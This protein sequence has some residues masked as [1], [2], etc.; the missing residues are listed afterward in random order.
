M[1]D[2][3]G[4]V[5]INP[6]EAS[7]KMAEQQSQMQG[8]LDTI[9]AA[10]KEMADAASK[11]QFIPGAGGE[12]AA[13]LIQ[14][15]QGELQAQQMTQKVAAATDWENLSVILGQ[16]IA[17]LAHQQRQL[18][19]KIM[20]DSAV[21][22]WDDP[23]TAIANAF[24]LPWD[25]QALDGIDTKLKTTTAMLNAAHGHVQQSAKSADAI[26]TKI[27]DAS[28][29]DVATA[30]E[31]LQIQTAA[32]A[33]LEAAKTGADVLNTA[34][35]MDTRQLDLY[36]K[37]RQM[38][39]QDEQMELARK[40]E[41]RQMQILDI[42]LKEIKDKEL[43][44]KEH[45]KFVN[46]ALVAEGRNPIDVKTFKVYK[47]SSAKLL[48]DLTAQGMKLAINGTAGYSHGSTIEDRF[49]W[50]NTI[51]WKPDPRIPQQETIMLMQNA[52]VKAAA[53]AT[54]NKSMIPVN[55]NQLFAKN[56]KEAQDDIREGSPFMAP[57]F[58]VIG[59]SRVGQHPIWQKYIAP[60]LDQN[61]SKN[62]VTPQFIANAV[63]Q[64]VANRE[65][66][67]SDAAQFASDVFKQAVAINNT[68]IEMKKIAGMEQ[69]KYGAKV[70]VGMAV[71]TKTAAD[72][73]GATGAALI[74]SGAGALPGSAL[75][76]IGVGTYALASTSMSIDA[77]DRAQWNAVI[78]RTV[79]SKLGLA[80][81]T[82]GTY[83]AGSNAFY[84]PALES[85]VILG[86]K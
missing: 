46:D 10:S 33:R 21:S 6:Y 57:S 15:R 2:T 66:P 37:N 86:A 78:A 75:M 26:A 11:P 3:A 55:A 30:A 5:G 13:S 18:T 64:A 42:Q 74:A 20:Q 79:A 7:V 81:N 76:G 50:Q 70:K 39:Q 56:F 83:P 22:L 82:G 53:E 58:S 27:T 35:Q 24:T 12:T 73:A 67:V 9:T 54:T 40:R 49:K 31:S 29:A 8:L 41:S 60:T 34:M 43:A 44:E 17:S 72:I 38:Q 80:L 62:P 61:T 77:T 85:S 51:G 25:Q 84:P 48:E 65:L 52:A 14:K 59:S 23:I 63:S 36:L 16:D 28:L 45:L 68:A 19:T 71:G 1:A 4:K 69:T 47:Q 32:K